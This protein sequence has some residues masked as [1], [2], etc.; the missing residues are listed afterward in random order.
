MAESKKKVQPGAKKPAVKPSGKITA[1]KTTTKPTVR[2]AAKPVTKST[3]SK[4][5]TKGRPS[6]PKKTV[7]KKQPPKR[8]YWAFPVVV[9]MLAVLTAIG[10]YAV[11]EV[12]NYRAF[13]A[14]RA[15]VE[16]DTF[17]DGVEIDGI[18]VGGGTLNDV[19]AHFA[20]RER[21]KADALSVALSYGNQ[22]W[23]I[24]GSDLQYN[25]NYE[26][27]IRSAYQ[28][29]RAGS[30][31]D[32][33]RQ[34][35]DVAE[36]GR[37]YTITRNYDAGLLREKIDAIAASLSHPAKDA[38][39]ASFDM[40]SKSF[41]FTQSS[42]GARVEAGK[43]YD[44]AMTALDSGGGRTVIINREEI[45]P[46]VSSSSLT[47]KFGRVSQAVT[48][49]SGSSKNRLT[50]IRL[51]LDIINGTRIGPGES[52]SYNKTVGQRTSA[53]GFKS[54]GAF[55]DGTL[56]EEIGGGIC[57]T[58]TTLFNAV[59]KADLEIVERSAHSRPVSYV[60]KGKDAAVSWPGPD[61]VFK[62]NTRDPVYLVAYLTSKNQVT[63]EV[64]GRLLPNG[65]SIRIDSKVTETLKPGGDQ[66]TYN[67]SLAP[68]ARRVVEQARNGYRATAYKVYL[69]KDGNQTKRVE[70]CK[71]TYRAAGAVVEVG[72]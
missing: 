69:D 44:Q 65:S 5:G 45:Q 28:I 30:L 70:L 11:Q 55:S 7:A 27:V 8:S 36:H 32:R 29:G 40:K 15:S 54:A 61:L 67:A 20:Q 49:A 62:N 38:T 71:S 43:L 1:K 41:S 50:N 26:S 22:Q 39:V 64:Y 60:D 51:A 53:R 14:M 66:I 2:T 72:P 24:S 9:L 56:I 13:A 33:F 35:N 19:R 3:A 16:R 58:S 47:G 59:V 68:G 31:E 17:Y 23:M 34:V 6:A 21:E 48:S 57:Q 4:T 25:S 52:F 10:L 46:A 18:N 12:A 42:A 63:V 37:R